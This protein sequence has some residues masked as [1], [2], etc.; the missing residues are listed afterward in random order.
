MRSI[1]NKTVMARV[2]YFWYRLGKTS[3]Y[4]KFGY[5][6]D[7][8]MGSVFKALMHELIRE[9]LAHDVDDL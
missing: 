5:L 9:V 8:L 3:I 7:A 2:R 6:S 1:F 4:P